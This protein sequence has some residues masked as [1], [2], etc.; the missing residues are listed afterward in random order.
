MSINIFDTISG[1]NGSG[2]LAG[3]WTSSSFIGTGQTG[4]FQPSGSYIT[5]NSA[6]FV[7]TGQTGQFY[8]SSN[9]SGFISGS[10]LISIFP[11]QSGNIVNQGYLNFRAPAI[12]QTSG[13][14]VKNSGIYN[15]TEAIPTGYLFCCN[16]YEFLCTSA[17]GANV[18]TGSG[19]F[20]AHVGHQFNYSGITNSGLFSG[21]I[22]GG[23]YIYEAPQDAISG[24]PNGTLL[25]L[26]ISSGA[27]AGRLSGI[28]V[29]EGNLI[30][31]L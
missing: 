16:K 24:N 7:T 23:R 5:G 10:S 25:G 12:Y 31:Y 18:G 9:P 26:Q 21:S 14:N 4:A 22:F 15:V 27:R 19:L 29:F 2:V 6:S 28:F 30:K 11:T 1:N 13:I 8:S 17:S 20:Y 3:S